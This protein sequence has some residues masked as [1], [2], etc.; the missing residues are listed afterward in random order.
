MINNAI[1]V[2][3]FGHI[4][5]EVAQGLYQKIESL[6]YPDS[7]YR[8]DYSMDSFFRPAGFPVFL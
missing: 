7:I 8:N 5:I 1:G 2:Q 6:V 4:Y 3:K